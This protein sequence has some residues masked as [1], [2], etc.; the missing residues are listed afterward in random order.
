MTAELAEALEAIEGELIIILEDYHF[1][2]ESAS[3]PRSPRSWSSCLRASSS[4]SYRART[5]VHV[6]RL[7]ANG[8]LLELPA[9]KL[10]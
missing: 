10:A 2:K 1:I 8:G 7:P 3:T 9:G 6:D 4:G 5:A